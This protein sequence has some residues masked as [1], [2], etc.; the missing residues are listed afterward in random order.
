MSN[1]AIT[2]DDVARRRLGSVSISATA[3]LC[4]EC[5]A[6]LAGLRDD[7]TEEDR[8]AALLAIAEHR[9]VSPECAR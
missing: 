2:F 6:R 5:D 1:P 3:V 8:R 7:A 9:R 4:Q